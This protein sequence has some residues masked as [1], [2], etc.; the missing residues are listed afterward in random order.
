MCCHWL[1]AVSALIL[2]NV[3]TCDEH[4]LGVGHPKAM[5]D[6]RDDHYAKLAAV[7]VNPQ[8]LGATIPLFEDPVLILNWS[9]QVWAS[10]APCRL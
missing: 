9:G 10:P 5:R 4:A 8:E 7:P 6:D 1:L 3:R 2:E